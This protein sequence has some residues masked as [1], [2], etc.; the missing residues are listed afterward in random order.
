MISNQ[1]FFV[2][3]NRDKNAEFS[4]EKKKSHSLWIKN[5][6]DGFSETVV[7]FNEPVAGIF[8][9]LLEPRLGRFNPAIF[10]SFTIVTTYLLLL[11]LLCSPWNYNRESSIFDANSSKLRRQWRRR[12]QRGRFSS[13]ASRPL[14]LVLN[15]SPH[16]T[17]IL[18]LFL[19][20]TYLSSCYIFFG[21]FSFSFPPSFSAWH[22]NS[23]RFAHDW[24]LF[25]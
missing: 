13:F 1:F 11:L 3:R 9:A 25:F 4:Y 22:K 19:L 12:L 16:A 10:I 14:T 5:S 20:H 18:T 15:I 23:M 24:I 8:V 7:I 2:A 6:N 21:L 17:T